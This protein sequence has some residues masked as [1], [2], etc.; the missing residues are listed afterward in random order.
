MIYKVP[1]ESCMNT[2]HCYGFKMSFNTRFNPLLHVQCLYFS[3]Q[4]IHLTWKQVYGCVSVFVYRIGHWFAGKVSLLILVDAWSFKGGTSL[5]FSHLTPLPMPSIEH[6]NCHLQARHSLITNVEAHVV[7]FSNTVNSNWRIGKGHF[8]PIQHHDLDTAFNLH[9]AY[10]TSYSLHY[11]PKVHI[12]T[13]IS[14][15]VIKQQVQCLT[16]VN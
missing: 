1:W 8:L 5:P 2:C 13:S 6:Y 12:K 16:K 7:I 4:I 3:D 14:P 11:P 15:L 9:K 10:S